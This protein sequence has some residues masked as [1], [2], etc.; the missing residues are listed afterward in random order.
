MNPYQ[1]DEPTQEKGVEAAMKTSEA[2][3]IPAFFQECAA[4]FAQYEQ[5]TEEALHRTSA[6]HEAHLALLERALAHLHADQPEAAEAALRRFSAE[7]EPRLRE[8]AQLQSAL[9]R[10]ER[11]P[12]QERQEALVRRLSEALEHLR[13][14]EREAERSGET[15]PSVR[16]KQGEDDSR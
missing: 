12:H 10:H 9:G 1:P 7:E 15:P 13:R 16:E 3:P 4:F 2:N 11:S 6:L 8:Q 14:A 5:A